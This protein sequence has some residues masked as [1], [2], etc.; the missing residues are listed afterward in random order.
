MISITRLVTILTAVFALA[1]VCFAQE[2]AKTTN[3]GNGA[4]FKGKTT[5]MKDRGKVAY[6]LSFKAGKQ[7]EATADG[8]KN[9]DVHLFVYD[10]T[11]K[12]VGKDESPGPKCSVKVTPA[13]DGKYRFVITNA[14][15]DNAVTLKVN[16]AE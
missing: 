7:F 5:E 14:G 13:Q 4:E 3:L 12:E 6:V 9:T 2:H 8:P 11:G 16:I 1:T 15:G 10:T